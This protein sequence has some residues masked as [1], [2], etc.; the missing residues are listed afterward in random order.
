MRDDRAAREA[1]AA[2]KAE[3]PIQGAGRGLLNKTPKQLI[4]LKQ[5][6]RPEA[7]HPMIAQASQKGKAKG[8]KKK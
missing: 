3:K 2:H 4:S 6:E 7:V 8:K 5:T 1:E